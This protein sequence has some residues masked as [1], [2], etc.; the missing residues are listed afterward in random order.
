MFYI[1]EFSQMSKTTIKTLHYYDRIGLLRPEKV[2]AASGYRM[3]STQQLITIHRIQSLQQTGLSINEILA[4][5]D[6]GD[7]ESILEQRK[8]DIE[9]EV[10]EGQEQLTRIAF[11]QQNIK[12]ENRMNYE[13]NIKDIPSLTVYTKRVTA[14]NFAAYNEIIPAIG[15]TVAEANPGL[16]CAKPEY[17]F[18]CY[19]DDEYREIDINI[20][21]N[22][23]VTK[24]GNEVDGIYF[25]DIDAVTVASILHQGSYQNMPQAYAFI[26]D[27]VEKNGYKVAER[28]RES[29]IDGIWNQSD[30]SKWLTEIQVPLTR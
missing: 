16:E 27:W 28:P 3:Y 10:R 24:K 22:E 30:E 20:E 5:F 6:E 9:N 19:L 29:Y 26:M 11:I 15:R 1:G 2:D 25:R 17:C 23:A 21:Y 12:E 4:V 7:I 14:P 13:V 8:A 18:I